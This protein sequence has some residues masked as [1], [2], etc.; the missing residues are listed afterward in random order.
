MKLWPVTIKKPNREE[1][2]YNTG[3]TDYQLGQPVEA[4]PYIGEEMRNAWI[5]GWNAAQKRFSTEGLR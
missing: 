2:A 1:E 3:Y 5:K 4:N